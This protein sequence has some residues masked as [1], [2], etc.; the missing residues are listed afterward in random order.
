MIVVGAGMAAGRALERLIEADPHAYDI[1]VFNAEPRG[2][3]NRIMLSPVLAGEKRF[4]EIVTHDA[5]WYARHGITC[6][7]GERLASIDP[8]AKIVT[9]QDG[10]V[11]PYD[12]LLLA[13]GSAPVIIPLP[14]HEV[15]GVIA[16]RDL[17]DTERMMAMGP[18][19]RVV[20]IG[21]GL[22]G[23]EAAAGMAARGAEVT[24]V[25]LMG[26]LMERQLDATAGGMLAESLRGRGI[27]VLCGANS[28]E[29]AGEAGKVRA[30]LL[31]DGT[32]LPC[33]LLVMA[34]GIRPNTA[35]A[36]A[37]GIETGRG[38]IVDDHMRSS[39]P[40]I[41]A[42]GE[43]VEHRGALFGLVAPCFDQAE[44][45]AQTLLGAEAVFTPRD[46]ATQL[47]VTGC[48]LFSAG[49]F[50]AGEERDEIVLHDPLRE[51]YR[52]LV[53]EGDR[54]IGAVFYGDTRDSAWFLDLIRSGADI[55]AIRETL[56]FGPVAQTVPARPALQGVAA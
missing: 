18:G 19:R 41:L 54:L 28:R 32:E 40:D 39:A 9:A 2:S 27:T 12:K 43:C 56:I 8:A 17:E 55:S 26:H 44:V 21:G 38:I 51:S 24:V 5:A 15:D 1:T 7:F 14:G 3:Y 35:L 42:I 20:V 34:V 10:E 48:A 4:A 16:Y 22:L 36:A 52:R 23:L 50:A 53:L 45:A 49:D 30:L 33:D 25:H 11:L 6:R 13:T 46:V 37:A 31:D 29:I 47:K